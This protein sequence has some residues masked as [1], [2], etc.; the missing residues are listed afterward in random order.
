MDTAKASPAAG[1]LPGKQAAGTE[2]GLLGDLRHSDCV[3]VFGL[4]PPATNPI[5]G[6]NLREAVL[7][8]TK[9]IVAGPCNTAP[10]RYA[11]VHL[12][13]YPGTEELVISGLLRLL[14]DSNQIDPEV[15][16]KHASE[17]KALREGLNEY[18]PET[19][20]K[21]TG[22]SMLDLVEAAC[23]VGNA[24]TL[25]IV[26]GPG[27]LTAT[28]APAT[29]AHILDALASGKVKA[30]Y[31][32]T[33]S[34]EAEPLESMSPWL[35]K[36][37]FAVIHDMAMPGEKILNALPPSCAFLPMAS[38][39]E[40]GGTFSSGGQKIRP[41]KPVRPAPEEARSALWVL[42]EL[43][44]I[45]GAPGFDYESFD[46][47]QEEICGQVP[48]YAD[49][50]L[51]ENR[52]AGQ[53]TYWRPKPAEVAQDG[54]DKEFPFALVSK[55]R[56]LPYF[57]GPLLADETAVL[58]NSPADVE[59][60]PADAFSMGFAPEDTVRVITRGG[61]WEGRLGMNHFLMPKMVA[62]A[63]SIWT[64]SGDPESICLVSAAKV[65]KR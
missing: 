8:G 5:A 37:D 65:E 1:V 56:L 26:Y 44:R 52:G 17:L 31:I 32:A 18:D 25:S 34:M 53:W 60:N 12:R 10:T 58:F 13:H 50:A 30:L 48:F 59:M 23:I 7:G 49:P 35:G 15:A 38:V 2:N 40:K 54:P 6:V 33:E 20:C 64:S 19:I 21:I 22:T 39:L 47:V 4:N 55:E 16:G 14:L 46:A 43:A 42:K 41:I 24:K 28:F 9:L 45:M 63:S 29:Q 61:E 57:L 36:L 51:S 62:V 3:L 11:D 27:V